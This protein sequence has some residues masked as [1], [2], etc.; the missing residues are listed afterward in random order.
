MPWREFPLS[1]P[2]VDSSVFISTPA[3]L[4]EHQNLPLIFLQI[5]A[6][7]LGRTFALIIE[8]LKLDKVKGMNILHCLQFGLDVPDE[9][10]NKPE[11]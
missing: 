5:P 11:P 7:N 9:N 8:Q 6:R 4:L 10:I 1:P 3:E 2:T